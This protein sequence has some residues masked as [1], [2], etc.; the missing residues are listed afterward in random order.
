[1]HSVDNILCYGKRLLAHRIGL[2]AVHDR[3]PALTPE[4]FGLAALWRHA[5]ALGV[6]RG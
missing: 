2:D 1:M 4:E 6:Q 5:R 3:A